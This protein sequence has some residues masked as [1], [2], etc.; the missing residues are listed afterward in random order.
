MAKR[1]LP[2]LLVHEEPWGQAHEHCTMFA[3]AGEE[4]YPPA[5]YCIAYIE[6]PGQAGKSPKELA[7]TRV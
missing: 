6:V 2:L 1:Q 3:A 7:K 5:H 4:K